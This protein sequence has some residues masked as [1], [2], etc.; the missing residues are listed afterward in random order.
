MLVLAL[1]LLAASCSEARVSIYQQEISP[2]YRAGEFGYAGARGAIR[3]VVAGD[4]LDTAPERLE[5]MVTEA[6]TGRHWGPRTNFTTQDHPGIRPSYRVIMM[7][8]PAPTMIGMRL[9]REEPATLPVARP[10][11]G[12]VLFAAF[13]RGGESMNEIKGRIKGA[14]GPDNLAFSELVGQVT[15]GL[16]PPERRPEDDKSAP[17]WLQSD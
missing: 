10:V 15:H 11:S 6:M 9:C 13:C 1:A 16:F 7:F 3:V 8:N 12:I 17:P 4:R 14:S 2:S 5:K